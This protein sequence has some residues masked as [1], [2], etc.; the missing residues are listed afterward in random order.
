MSAPRR[1]D[2]LSRI[3]LFAG[4]L[5]LAFAIAGLIARTPVGIALG[6]RKPT[7][8]AIEIRTTPALA[9]A[10]KLDGVYRGRT[11][12]RMDGVRAGRR[13]LELQVDGYLPVERA[14]DLSGGT[15]AMVDIALAARVAPPPTAAA[16]APTPAPT[17][18]TGH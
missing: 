2:R 14:V 15:T 3:L 6:L 7:T 17:A 12:L 13:V 10:V 18:A 1:P 8:G 11:P 16:A 9:A 4:L 5:L